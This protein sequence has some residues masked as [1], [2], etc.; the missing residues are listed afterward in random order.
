MRGRRARE[1][2]TSDTDT[3]PSYSAQEQQLYR[4]LYNIYT[5]YSSCIDLAKHSKKVVQTNLICGTL[6]QSQSLHKC[7]KINGVHK[8]S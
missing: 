6:N 2:F 8:S 5:Y 7:Y 1:Q 3:H 4:L